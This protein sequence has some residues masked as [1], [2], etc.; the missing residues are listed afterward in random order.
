[1]FHNVNIAQM[2]KKYSPFDYSNPKNLG[3]L[4]FNEIKNKTFSNKIN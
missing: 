2:S 4:E 3:K 1:M